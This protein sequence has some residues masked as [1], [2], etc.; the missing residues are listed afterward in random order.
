MRRELLPN[1]HELPQRQL[2]L[3]GDLQRQLL[4][5][6]HEMRDRHLLSQ[7]P[8]LHHG[9]LC[10]RLRVRQ[11]REVLRDGPGVRHLM[12]PNRLDL[13]GRHDVLCQRPN[14]WHDLLSG[15]SGVFRCLQL[16]VWV[17]FGAD[18][19]RGDLHDA[20]GLLWRNGGLRGGNDLRSSAAT[21]G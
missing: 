20:R 11:P 19:L 6:E 3:R 2:L 7:Q 17:S 4:R 10:A 15:G 8:V 5:G 16:D 18:S 12:L 14:L 21:S 13:P 1:G 9:V